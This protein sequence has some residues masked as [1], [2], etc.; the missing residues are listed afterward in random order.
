MINH[1]RGNVSE[2]HVILSP[3]DLVRERGDFI[4]HPSHYGGEDNPYEAIKVIEAWELDFNLGN[5]LK[6]ISRAGKKLDG[7]LS[8]AEKKLED[9]K[10]AAWYAQEAVRQ[11][12]RKMIYEVKKANSVSSENIDMNA[13]N[14]KVTGGD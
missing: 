14:S 6:Y 2:N 4:N 7:T 1:S 12:E 10:K 11:Q 3:E 8:A 13:I 5:C 9:L